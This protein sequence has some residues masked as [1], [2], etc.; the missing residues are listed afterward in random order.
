MD[1]KSLCGLELYNGILMRYVKASSAYLGKQEDAVDFNIT[2]YRSKDP[3]APR[4]YQDVLEKIEQMA[5]FKYDALPHWGKNRN[6]VFDRVI[7]RYKNGGEFLK[8]KNTNRPLGLF[9]SKWTDQ[10]LGLRN[11]VTILKE[12]C[13][14]EGLCICSQDVYRAPSK[15]YLVGL[16]KL[17]QMQEC[18]LRIRGFDYLVYSF[19]E[20]HYSYMEKK[21]TNI[22]KM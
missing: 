19:I 3:M 7:K 2:Y 20:E 14:L 4:L 15:G 5:L 1:P 9:S 21:T 13:T 6:L 17:L 22:K 12:G 18:A 16:G 10:V 8:V 11:G